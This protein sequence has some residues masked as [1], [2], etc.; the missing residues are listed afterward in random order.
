MYCLCASIES[1]EEVPPYKICCR[2]TAGMTI[3]GWE[4]YTCLHLILF[5]SASLHIATAQVF[6]D[7]FAFRQTLGPS[8]GLCSPW[9]LFWRTYNLPYGA[10][11]D[12]ILLLLASYPFPHYNQKGL[13][14]KVG[15]H[16]GECLIRPCCCRM[17]GACSYAKG[18]HILSRAD[19]P[20]LCC[21]RWSSSFSEENQ[22][23]CDCS[24]RRRPWKWLSASIKGTPE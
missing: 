4:V 16:V 13:I 1:I 10:R 9:A 21:R 14:G 20:D 11:F 17:Y 15:V 12:D 8:S 7:I 23:N 24:C 5:P 18:G 19:V 3:G 22:A 6:Q 2:E